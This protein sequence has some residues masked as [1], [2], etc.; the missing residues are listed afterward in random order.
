[1]TERIRGAAGLAMS[2]IM[3]AAGI[4][5]AGDPGAPPTPA[6]A[7]T[8]TY[9]GVQVSDPYRWLEDSASPKVEAWSAAEDARTRKYFDGLKLRP[10][11]G[12]AFPGR[13]V[14]QSADTYSFLFDQLG[15]RL[16]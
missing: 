5:R 13:R 11:R 9:H 16:R 1:M 4:A 6:Q 10:G 8:N 2:V 15:M 12:G 3:L 14:N 7:V